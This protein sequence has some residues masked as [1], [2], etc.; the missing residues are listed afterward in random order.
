MVPIFHVTC[1]TEGTAHS[2][3]TTRAQSNCFFKMMLWD[4]GLKLQTGPSVITACAYRT[5]HHQVALWIILG[6]PTWLFPGGSKSTH[7]S[8]ASKAASAR[9][10][11]PVLMQIM[12]QAR[13][14]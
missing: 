14:Y 4:E 11:A 6:K 5:Q 9:A 10:I 12:P 13:C 7:I 3:A 2:G 8:K 1:K